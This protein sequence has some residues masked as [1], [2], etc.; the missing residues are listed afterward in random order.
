MLAPGQLARDRAA[1]PRRGAGDQ[2]GWV[3]EGSGS[4]TAGQIL[5]SGTEPVPPNGGNP[6]PG[7]YPR[8]RGASMARR[9][10]LTALLFPG[11]GSQT[12]QM[13]DTV[14]RERPDLLEQAVE[15][16]GED[17]FARRGGGHPL[18][19]AGDL[20]RQPGRLAGSGDARGRVHGRPLARASSRR[21]S[22]PARWRE[23]D[24]L[25]LVALRGALMQEAGEQAGDGGMIALLGS[26]A[27]EHAPD[28]ADAHGLSV[29]N[30][31]SPAQIVLSGAR[32]AL[33]DA[34]E[35]AQALGLRSM[36]LPVTGA[37]HSPMMAAAVPEFAA[38]LAA[39]GRRGRRERRCS[40]RSPRPRSTTCA[41][42]SPRRSTGRCAG[43]RRCWR[44]TS[45]G[46]ERFVEVGPGRVLTGLA[47]R[48]VPGVELVHA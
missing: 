12:P 40:V 33:P 27:A 36:V 5:T 35:A 21:W 31:N 8:A 25:R 41:G 44:C 30:D 37:F 2:R 9:M 26:G 32:E 14:A 7:L 48:T 23:L 38:A 39:G 18:R 47:K 19:A 20:L 13:R 16:V 28:L 1:D 3:G 46:A 15:V 4:D 10:A 17:P 11:Q 22:P 45:S 29:A 43:A 42:G 34:A 6:R 24:G